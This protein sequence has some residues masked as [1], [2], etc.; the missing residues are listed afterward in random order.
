MRPPASGSGASRWGGAGPRSPSAL[1][2]RRVRGA[3]RW[4]LRLRGGLQMLDGNEANLCEVETMSKLEQLK[5]SLDPAE[6]PPMDVEYNEAGDMV[7]PPP[8]NLEVPH[9]RRAR[10]STACARACRGRMSGAPHASAG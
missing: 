2:V 7:V 3:A 4:P 9:A 8:M 1:R 10:A 5:N 6:Y